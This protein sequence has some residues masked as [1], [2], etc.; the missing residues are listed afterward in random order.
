[1]PDLQNSK[2]TDLTHY[3]SIDDSINFIGSI[4]TR[5]LPKIFL[6]PWFTSLRRFMVTSA[7]FRNE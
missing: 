1:M 2:T 6:R 7:L 4:P 5:V 3:L